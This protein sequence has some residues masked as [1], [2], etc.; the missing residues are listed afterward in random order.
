MRKSLAFITFTLASTFVIAENEISI[1]SISANQFRLT[2][3]S[4]TMLDVAAAQELLVPTAVSLCDG[5]HPQYGHYEFESDEN[6]STNSGSKSS[7]IFELTQD[8]QCIDSPVATVPDSRS[9]VADADAQLAI[10]DSIRALSE[11]YFSSL[12]AGRIDEAYGHLSDS[13]KSYRSFDEWN[14]QVS[15]FRNSAGELVELNLHTITVYDNP[16][17]S[18]QPG[19]YVAVDYQ[20]RFEDAPYHC[21]YLVWYRAEVGSFQIMREETGLI[22]NAIL[23]EV[24]K[25]Q[26]PQL[27]A[28]MRCSAR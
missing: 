3:N 12:I 25:G 16:P 26:L 23:G 17:N 9:F 24:P 18:P 15:E 8:I 1:E 20:N 7:D 10:E 5:K 13:M 6:I 22:T 14:T 11:S 19:I 2:L 21:G 4:E 28:Q 27:L